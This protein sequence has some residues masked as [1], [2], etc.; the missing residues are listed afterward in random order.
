MEMRA[1]LRYRRKPLKECVRYDSRFKRTKSYPV[2]SINV[3]YRLKHLQ[4]SLRIRNRLCIVLR[5]VKIKSVGAE[6]YSC[7]NNLMAATFRKLPHLI[8]NILNFSASYSSSCKRN[9]TVCAELITTILNLNICPCMR[10]ACID[11]KIFIFSGLIYINKRIIYISSFEIFFKNFDNLS[12][13]VISYN[14]IYRLIRKKLFPGLL[15]ITACSHNNRIRI[16]L[17]SLVKHLP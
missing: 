16:V 5:I 13:S 15:D 3:S 14:Y 8:N 11:F 7:H 10:R 1:Y 4:K 17:L 12:L 2:N 6:M 9:N